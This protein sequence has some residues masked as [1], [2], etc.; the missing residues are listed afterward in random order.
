[1]VFAAAFHLH[2]RQMVLRAVKRL[3]W[4]AEVRGPGSRGSDWWGGL[5]QGRDWHWQGQDGSKKQLY[6]R[7][8]RNDRKFCSVVYATR[9]QGVQVVWRVA[10]AGTF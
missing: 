6:H 4:R 5:S 9:A 8:I 2:L 10:S 1:M 3:G 7:R